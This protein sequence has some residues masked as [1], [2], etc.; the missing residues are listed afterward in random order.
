VKR[1]LFEGNHEVTL[2][3]IDG[4]Q[5]PFAIDTTRPSID[6]ATLTAS[7]RM[8]DGLDGTRG[9]QPTVRGAARD[10][11][12]DMFVNFEGHY[13][14]QFTLHDA[15]TGGN[16][17]GGPLTNAMEVVGGLVQITLD[18][19]VNAFAGEPPWLEIGVRTGA[20]P[21]FVALE[22]RQELL[23]TP[24]A[25]FAS[26]AAGVDG[27]IA[28]DQL[29]P[30]IP[31][32][33]TTN[34]FTGP[35]ILPPDGLRVADQFLFVNGNVGIGTTDP[36]ARLEVRCSR[37]WFRRWPEN[38]P[39]CPPLGRWPKWPGTSAGRP[40]GPGVGGRNSL[41]DGTGGGCLGPGR[42]GRPGAGGDSRPARDDRAHGSRRLLPLSLPTSIYFR[43]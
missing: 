35:L 30:N 41:A 40:S 22:P 26:R 5:S 17:V 34:I 14:L 32:L 6:K 31:R 27:L 4:V 8:R 11:Q 37:C 23:P 10:R 43:D 15:P 36:E 29:S 9:T 13:E 21:D 24:Y 39:A 38:G 42:I 1:R 33:N 3:T 18:F 28:D 2:R 19:G 7:D 12:P 25:I 20:E 16:V